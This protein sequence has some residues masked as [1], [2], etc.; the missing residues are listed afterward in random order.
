MVGLYWNQNCI[1]FTWKG[2]SIVYKLQFIPIATQCKEK[3]ETLLNSAQ[4]HNSCANGMLWS[5]TDHRIL[6]VNYALKAEAWSDRKFLKGRRRKKQL[7][8]TVSFP[9]K[10]CVWRVGAKTNPCV[11]CSCRK[12][13]ALIKFEAYQILCLWELLHVKYYFCPNYDLLYLIHWFPFLILM[14]QSP[15]GFRCSHFLA[16]LVL[17]NCSFKR[18]LQNFNKCYCGILFT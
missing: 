3:R 8:E 9:K 2:A 13:Q 12:L 5:W 1:S 14:A 7:R 15:V 6:W 4:F 10:V 16:Y 11:V 17:I 18:I